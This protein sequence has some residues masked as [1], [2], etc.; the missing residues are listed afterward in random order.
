MH[1]NP[2]T[3]SDTPS[4]DTEDWE[5]VLEPY[6]SH[7]EEA[8]S[9]ARLFAIIRKHL[10]ST[11]P[12][13][14]EAVDALDLAIEALYQHTRF[15]SGSYDLYQTVIEGRATRADETLAES[16]GVKL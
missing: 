8:L 14:P 4:L 6:F 7:S 1:N 11:P 9:L 3:D 10:K 2:N 5:I 15:Q 13:V 16:L 12:D